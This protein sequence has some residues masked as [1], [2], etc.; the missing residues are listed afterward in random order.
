[1]FKRWVLASLLALGVFS[2]RTADAIVVE[3]VVAV[4]GERAIFLTDLR[5]R[6]RPF[7]ESLHRRVPAGPQRAAA[8]S[9]LY[10]QLLD[11]MVEEHLESIAATRSHTT[12]NSREV[13]ETLAKIASS[14]KLSVTELIATV[15][16]Q[17]GMTEQEYRSEVRKQVLEGK[18]L[19]RLMQNQLRI[20]QQELRSTYERV[21]E[22]ELKSR[23]YRPAWIVVR[24]G[25]KPSKSVIRAAKAKLRRAAKRV[26]AG[27]PFTDVAAQLS[28][29][30]E[31]RDRGGD[32]GIRAPS[33]SQADL[34]GRKPK[35]APELEK[36]ALGTRIDEISEPFAY[37][38]AIAILTINSRQPSRY[39]TLKAARGEMMQ[40]VRARKLDKAKKKWLKQL[41]R[42]THVDV[43][44]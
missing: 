34:A 19:N 27:E 36:V 7:L 39:T 11:R 12:V 40:R 14:A 24:V 8:E 28:E 42:G 41:R 5:T 43:R 29:D 6:S 26:R 3:R 25:D 22:Q 13:D 44:L 37:R 35:L 38:D 1:M 32:L 31:T 4:I 15:R 33:G 9:K 17:E 20:T 2:T 21:R 16:A 10:H 23:L 18:L 30:P